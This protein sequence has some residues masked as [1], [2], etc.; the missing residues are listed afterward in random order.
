MRGGEGDMRI[1]ADLNRSVAGHCDIEYFHKPGVEP[2]FVAPP[3]VAS[4]ECNPIRIGSIRAIR[5]LRRGVPFVV[6]APETS[7]IA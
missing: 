2:P 5:Q 3:F 1:A 6:L 4:G 7:C